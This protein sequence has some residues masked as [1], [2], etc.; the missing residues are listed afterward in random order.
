M[1]EEELLAAI[2]IDPFDDGLIAALR[3][4]RRRGVP[5]RSRARR[6]ETALRNLLAATSGEEAETE[7]R[8]AVAAWAGM[9]ALHLDLDPIEASNIVTEEIESDR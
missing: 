5:G 7:R 9:L 1:T 4:V 2:A 3:D 6:W 8:D